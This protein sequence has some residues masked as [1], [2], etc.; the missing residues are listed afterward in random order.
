MQQVIENPVKRK[1]AEKGK[2]DA[3]RPALAS[4]RLKVKQDRERDGNGESEQP[5]NGEKAQNPSCYAEG[6][7]SRERGLSVRLWSFYAR[8]PGSYQ[9]CNVGP[10]L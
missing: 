10:E 5:D 8:A 4:A 2:S 9:T 7:L 3:D 1:P 6:S